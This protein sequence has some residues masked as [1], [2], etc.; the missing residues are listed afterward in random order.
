MAIF[1]NRIFSPVTLGASAEAV[2]AALDK[3]RL[4]RAAQKD[5]PHNAS[6][7]GIQSIIVDGVVV[8]VTDAQLDHHK[9]VGQG[10]MP[11]LRGRKTLVENQDAANESP[12]PSSKGK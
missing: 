4:A 8:L 5:S 7:A 1:S 3:V 6:V 10:T 12:A 9:S 2:N 11:T